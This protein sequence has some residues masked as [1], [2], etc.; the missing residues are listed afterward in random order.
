MH[1]QHAECNWAHHCPRERT[2][3]NSY[4]CIW[5]STLSHPKLP[6]SSF[7]LPRRLLLEKKT[8]GPLGHVLI[9]KPW[10]HPKKQSRQQHALNTVT[11]SSVS[12]ASQEGRCKKAK[13]RYPKHENPQ[14]PDVKM[15]EVWS[16]QVCGAWGTITLTHR[17]VCHTTDTDRTKSTFPGIRIVGRHQSD[18]ILG[19][20]HHHRL[21]NTK[22]QLC[23][24][25]SFP[26]DSSQVVF[27]VVASFFYLKSRI[28]H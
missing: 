25:G 14:I 10:Y 28:F 24:K 22:S 6:V 20:C 12:H 18:N 5:R 15:P 11:S 23:F 13:I 4:I 9:Q 26:K 7:C 8:Q 19:H 16:R 21:P 17:L 3:Y 2:V 27:V 1:S